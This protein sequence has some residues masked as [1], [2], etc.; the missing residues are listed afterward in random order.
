MSQ[1]STSDEQTISSAR[2]TEGRFQAVSSLRHRNFQ[3]YLSGQLVSLAGTWMQRVAQGWLVYQLSRSEFTLGLVEFASAIPALLLSLWG[4]V[5]VDR[6]SRRNILVATQAS[7][8]ILAFVLA[9][10]TF[11]GVV[12]VWHVI[13]IAIFVGFVNALDGP[14]RQAFVVEMVGKE[15]LPNAIALNSITFNLA[16]VIGPAFG[17]WLLIALGAAWCFLLNGF[18]FLS[19]IGSLLWMKLPKHERS[20]RHFSPWLQMREGLLYTRAN[21]TVA[22]LILLSLILSLFGIAYLAVLPAYVD[23]VLQQGAAEYGWLNTAI[24]IG[25]IISVSIIAQ[26]GKSLGRGRILTTLA[27]IFPIVLGLFAFNHWLPL[28]LVFAA[29]L[30]ALF[31]GEYVL[32]NTLLQTE[33][34]DSMRGR[35]LSLYTITFFGFTPFG[36]LGTGWLAEKIGLS[37]AIGLCALCTFVFSAWILIRTPSIRRLQ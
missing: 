14:A 29:L 5:I 24:G 7:A 9:A 22:G 11:A 18:S 34:E 2:P 15:D 35:V 28:A 8:M 36:S 21:A 19:V 4:G 17:G 1:S 27:L 13:V 10:L 32:L 26:A 23:K 16:R 12:Q 37:V 6:F 3:L 33:I 20:L 25:A 31:I 30:G